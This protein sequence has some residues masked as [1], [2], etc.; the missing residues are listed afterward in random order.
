MTVS[1]TLL[2]AIFRFGAVCLE[3]LF[4]DNA[5]ARRV[6]QFRLFSLAQLALVPFV[7]VDLLNIIARRSKE[8]ILKTFVRFR[9]VELV[10]AGRLD[11]LVRGSIAAALALRL[12]AKG[13]EP[14][15]ASVPAPR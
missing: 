6:C 7:S 14:S 12:A 1:V 11:R 9:P 4:A 8:R 13:D 5:L 15:P 3:R 10:D 2:R